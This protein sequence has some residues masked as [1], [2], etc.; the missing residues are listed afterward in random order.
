MKLVEINISIFTPP[1]PNYHVTELI[2]AMNVTWVIYY[3]KL[4]F[5]ESKNIQETG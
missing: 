4:W 1:P 3:K 5:L 2:A